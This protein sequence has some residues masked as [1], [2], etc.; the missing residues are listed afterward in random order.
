MSEVHLAANMRQMANPLFWLSISSVFAYAWM[1]LVTL[2]KDI[3]L[4]VRRAV[5]WVFLP[6]CCAMVYAGILRELRIFSDLSV[7]V[8]LAVATG[9]QQRYPARFTRIGTNVA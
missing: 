5:L 7:L 8:V 4:A 2:W 9:L 6:W 1:A 3:P